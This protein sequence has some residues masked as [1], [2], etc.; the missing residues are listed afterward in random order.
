VA[1]IVQGQILVGK[2]HRYLGMNIIARSFYMMFVMILDDGDCFLDKLWS[3]F[4]FL[5]VRIQEAG[6]HT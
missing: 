4:Q 6:T 3:P 1:E 2:W 5:P